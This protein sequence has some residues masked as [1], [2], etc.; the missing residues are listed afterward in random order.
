MR[1]IV[2]KS[3]CFYISFVEDYYNHR[4]LTAAVA[5]IPTSTYSKK[6]SR[7]EVDLSQANAVQTFASAYNFEVS[8][9]KPEFVELNT[10]LPNLEVSIPLKLQPYTYQEGGIAYGLKNGSCMNGDAPGLGKTLQS[11][12]TVIGLNLFP[13]LVICPA[14]LKYNWELEW[15]LFSDKKPHIITDSTKHT[16]NVFADMGVFDVMIVNYES[17][18]KY[19]TVSLNKN[20]PNWT[21]KDIDFHPNI[22][23][24]KSVIIDEA[25]NIID[26]D[27]VKSKLTYGIC[28]AK[29]VEFVNPLS[30]TFYVN[31]PIDLLPNIMVCK[32][33]H[34]FGGVSE[35]RKM[36]ADN[37]RW[38]EIH[39]IL[40]KH[41]YFR[42]EKKE[43]LKDLPDITRIK[44]FCDIDNWPE[45]NAAQADLEQY[46]KEYKQA[47]DAQVQKS[48]KGKAM[49]M[50]GVLKNIAARGKLWAVTE[51]INS[52]IDS[53]EKLVSFIFLTEVVETLR[54]SYPDALLFTG[55]Q[56]DHEKE[57]N[58]HEF[59]RCTVC[60]KRFERHEGEDHE[61]V[62]T[63]KNLIFVNYKSGG[64]GHTFTASS[65]CIH[66]ELPW[67]YKD[68]EQ[69]E[70]RVHRNSQKNAVTSLFPIAKG[71]IEET[72]Y[73]LIMEKKEASGILTGAIDSSDEQAMNNIFDMLSK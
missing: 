25:H 44:V 39:A 51:Y 35:F 12:A 18:A 21:V 14:S 3:N 1:V 72:I 67:T 70:G 2:Q 24:F 9:S 6:Y 5:K 29:N 26:T 34:H 8:V 13:C 22:N 59:Q 73:E 46:L 31:K 43:V 62:P 4:K 28:M 56:T 37:E 61:F 30:G 55:K 45:Y 49:V 48:L 36:C 53:G 10:E 52:V 57:A 17:L 16:W 7:W 27:T 54:K 58:K 50:I 40:R 42:R 23:L 19:F 47:T 63:D 66:I 65:N 20:R 33:V 32:K 68:V 38:P 64:V 71:T 60:N 11:I 41:C 15:K 69:D